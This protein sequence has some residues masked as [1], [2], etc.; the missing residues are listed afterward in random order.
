VAILQLREEEYAT[1]LEE[2]EALLK[3]ENLACRTRIAIEVR[4][5]GK[6]VL[7]EAIQEAKAFSGSNK[8]MRGCQSFRAGR[9]HQK[10]SRRIIPTN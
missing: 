1:T 9:E 5:G 6:R 7:R 2:D 4:L 8:H 3:G 10:D